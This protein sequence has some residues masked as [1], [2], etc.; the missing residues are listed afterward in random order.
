MACVAPSEGQ[1]TE[2]S[3]SR[4]SKEPNS[5]RWV[6]K[7]GCWLTFSYLG[8]HNIMHS[9]AS[10]LM[11]CH[12]NKNVCNNPLITQDEASVAILREKTIRSFVVH[13][14]KCQ[15]CVLYWHQVAISCNA[16]SQTFSMLRKPK[17]ILRYTT[18]IFT[19]LSRLCNVENAPRPN[20]PSTASKGIPLASSS[21]LRGFCHSLAEWLWARRCCHSVRPHRSHLY[22][23][24]YGKTYIREGAWISKRCKCPMSK[25]VLNTQ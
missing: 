20:S 2:Y 11:W 25:A 16:I 12:L 5:L 22:S 10:P 17:G 8:K 18:R 19:S 9:K 23:V 14:L 15:T 6:C 24:A 7:I 21:F 4:A 13:I 3:L 1:K